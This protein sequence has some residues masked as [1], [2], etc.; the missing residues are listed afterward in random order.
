MHSMT[1]KRPQ[2][3]PN[4]QVSVEDMNY[5]LIAS[6]KLDG[7]RC[8]IQNGQL[9]SRSMKPIPNRQFVETCPQIQRLLAISEE[10]GKVFDGELY[11]PALS[12]QEITS[13]VMSHDKEIPDS[14]QFWCFDMPSAKPFVDRL[15][16][17]HEHVPIPCIPFTYVETPTE[18]LEFFDQAV[19]DGYEGLILLHPNSR[20]KQGRITEKAGDGY[21]LKPYETFDSRIIG[22]VQ[23]TEVDPDAEKTINELGYS[24]TSK[25]KDDRIPIGKAAAFEVW[26]PEEPTYN[27]HIKE[28]GFKVVKVT[29]AMT[30]AE[31]EE[32]W[33]NREDYIGLMIEWKGLLVGAKD[34]PRH[35]CFLRFREDKD[36]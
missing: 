18:T 6:Y 12:F 16:E 9:Y 13:V 20:Y 23:A 30:D 36:E 14:L 25:K 10:E 22:V 19:T 29:L 21:K 8:I 15:T 24:E 33:R 27:T 11:S 3:F 28:E 34:V 35:P 32:V 26:W 5:P 2:L 7:I 17:V 31:K 1:L 4:T